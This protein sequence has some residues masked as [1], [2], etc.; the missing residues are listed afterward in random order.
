[1]YSNH[2][3]VGR[4]GAD[5][6]MAYSREGDPRTTFRLAVDVGFGDNK[7]TDWIRVTVWG[8]QAEAVNA[9]CKKGAKVLVEGDDLSAY[10][11]VDKDSGEARATL[12]L[13]ARGV[14]F[15]DSKRDEIEDRAPTDGRRDLPF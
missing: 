13:K 10:P 15:L 5:P 14:R 12:Q 11:Y 3:Y 7:R 9:Y 2:V 1:M 8:K 4:L 6:E